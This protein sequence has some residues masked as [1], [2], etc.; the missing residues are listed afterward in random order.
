MRSVV[1]ILCLALLPATVHANHIGIYDDPVTLCVATTPPFG[2][3]FDVYVILRP[4]TGTTA[5]AYRVQAALPATLLLVA[6]TDL[7]C[8]GICEPFPFPDPLGDGAYTMPRACSSE[9]WPIWRFTFIR[10]GPVPGCN[11]FS[12][13]AH[14]DETSL[15][16]LDCDANPIPASGGT[17]SMADAPGQCGGC[18]LATESTTWGAVKALYR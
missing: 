14:A 13:V 10:L 9:D 7:S 12:V 16:A 11:Q 3:P 15:F 4:T 1:L 17:F 6:G 8:P 2:T 5:A 18:T